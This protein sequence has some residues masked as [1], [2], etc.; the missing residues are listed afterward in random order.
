[1]NVPWYIPVLVVIITAVFALRAA[2]LLEWFSVPRRWR[3]DAR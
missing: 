2:C 1:M 3:S